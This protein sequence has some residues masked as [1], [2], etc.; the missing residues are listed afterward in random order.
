MLVPVLLASTMVTSVRSEV[1]IRAV[2][3]DDQDVIL[4]LLATGLDWTRDE[5]HGALFRWKHV[6]N[7]FGSSFGWI[8]EVDGEPAGLR[9][10]MRWDLMD[11][12]TTIRA[13]RAVDTV[14]HPDHRGRGVFSA[15]ARHAVAHIAGESVDFVFNT[16]NDQ[17]RPGYLKL[18]WQ[19]VDRVQAGVGLRP[20]RLHRLPNSRLPAAKWSEPTTVGRPAPEVFDDRVAVEALLAARAPLPGVSTR[21]DVPFLRWRFGLEALHYRAEL[22]GSTVDDGLVV[23]RLRRRGAGLEV[24]VVAILSHPDGP[25]V[26]PTLRR[27]AREND[28]D[29]VLAAGPDVSLR[30]GLIPVPRLGPV[31]V[32]LPIARA[33]QP[34]RWSLGLGDVELF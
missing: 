27:I 30:H 24:A 13:V 4:D 26:G 19:E 11:A 7:P 18:G 29:H 20:R 23:Y 1:S 31:L 22:I 21:L 17:S 33:D 28:A 32:W 9:L 8:A 14:T 5:R 16:P 25:R 6:D 34:T 12:G 15:L 10:L 3:P 2:G